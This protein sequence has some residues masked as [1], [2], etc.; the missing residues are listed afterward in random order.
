MYIYN[1]NK[2]TYNTLIPVEKYSTGNS[3]WYT[4]PF[5]E[6]YFK[7]NIFYIMQKI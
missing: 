2:F 1:K 4:S 6:L 5:I 3:P 7:Q